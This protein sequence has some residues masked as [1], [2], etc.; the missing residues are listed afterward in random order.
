MR[1]PLQV[2]AA[3][4]AGIAAHAAAGDIPQ[5][6]KPNIVFIIADQWRAQAFGFAGDPN[7]Q[8]PNLDRFAREACN[9]DQAVSGLPVCSPARASILT[10]QRPLKHGVF[11]NDAPLAPATPSI[12]DVLGAAGYDTGYIGKW[13]VDGHGRLTFIPR[14][15]RHGFDY[16]KTIEC[17]H[18]YLNSTYYT[19]DETTPRKWE[20]YDAQAQSR[21]A[22]QYL[23]DHATAA[24]PFVLFL[25][26]GPPHDPYMQ[27]PPE[28]KDRYTGRSFK[29]RPNV[30]ADAETKARNDLI[31]YYAHCTALDTYFGELMATLKDTGLAA[32]TIVVFTS[33]HGNL[34]G[35]HDAWNKQQPYDESIRVPFL[36]RW[37]AGLG[38]EGRRLAAPINSED[39]MPTLLGL[40]GTAVPASAEGIDYSGYLR[41]GADPSDGAALITCVAP[42]GQWIRAM[43]GK[44][45]RGVRTARYTYVRDLQGPWLLFD[46]EKDPFQQTNVVNQPGYKADQ[47]RLD[48]QLQRKLKANGDEF[49]PGADYV[50]KW[51]YHVDA[52]GTIPWRPAPPPKK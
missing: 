18:N 47:D 10:G 50:A 26:W 32:N 52:T 35:S 51:G 28:M 37:P 34:L 16:W 46:N 22:G 12:A 38:Q 6:N 49:L 13:H 45:Y 23:R 42:F 30:P 39:V 2:F 17:N 41:G 25:A 27:V 15:R 3:C 36:L 14:E 5:A 7:V 40:A 33:D 31:G 11:L 19:G 4:L 44:E 1:W 48:A 9:F 21:D 8:T 24:K 43:G 20:G 29:L